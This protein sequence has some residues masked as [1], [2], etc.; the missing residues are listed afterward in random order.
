MIKK[1]LLLLLT[2]VCL[3]SAKGDTI[4][5]WH[6]YYND[7]LIK[8]FNQVG[9]SNVVVIK[10]DEIKNTDS[11]T[12]RFYDDTPCNKCFVSL[13]VRDEK[14]DKLKKVD[15]V[16]ESTIFKLSIKELQDI[17]IKNKSKYYEFVFY[18]NGKLRHQLFVLYVK[19]E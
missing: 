3:L 11:I 4:D 7:K 10:N 15:T 17:G 14:E 18:T 1:T 2:G 6:V 5:F 8:E 16:G 12:I 19:I 9:Y 13:I